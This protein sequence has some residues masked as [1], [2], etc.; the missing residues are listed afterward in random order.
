MVDWFFNTMR[1]DETRL[2]SD[3]IRIAQFKIMKIL[4][5]EN[6]PRMSSPEFLVILNL[7]LIEIRR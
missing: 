5:Y 6:C 4:A 7:E 2:E 3:L 1:A